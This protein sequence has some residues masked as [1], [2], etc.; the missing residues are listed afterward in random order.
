[1]FIDC[2]ICVVVMCLVELCELLF[3]LMLLGFFLSC[4]IMFFMVLKGELV[5]SMK[6]LYLVV[7]CVMGVSWVMDIGGLLVIRLLSMIVFMII[8]VL[9]LFLLVL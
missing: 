3:Y 8:R 5:G 9:G 2:V 6:M 7:R 1:M 4:L